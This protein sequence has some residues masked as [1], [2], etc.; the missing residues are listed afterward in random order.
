MP[1]WET[2]YGRRPES[3]TITAKFKEDV[4]RR[5]FTINAMGINAKGEIIDYCIDTVYDYGCAKLDAADCYDDLD[6]CLREAVFI[7]DS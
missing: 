3:V 2:R 1:S 7:L 4:E 6:Q 5:D